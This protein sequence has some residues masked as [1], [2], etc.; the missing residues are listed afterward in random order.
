MLAANRLCSLRIENDGEGRGC[1]NDRDMFLGCDSQLPHMPSKYSKYKYIKAQPKAKNGA[2]R[3]MTMTWAPAAL[4]HCQNGTALIFAWQE[5]SKE[6]PC[7]RVHMGVHVAAQGLRWCMT[8]LDAKHLISRDRAVDGSFCLHPQ[9][10]HG[11]RHKTSPAAKKWTS[12]CLYP[13]GGTTLD[14]V[15]AQHRLDLGPV[16]LQLQCTPF[17]LLSAGALAFIL[18]AQLGRKELQVSCLPS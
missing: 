12:P 4:A 16:H 13:P 3:D 5:S 18:N 14:E 7:A 2:L 15:P 9:L 11:R 6:T 10:A 1:E 8:L 17:L